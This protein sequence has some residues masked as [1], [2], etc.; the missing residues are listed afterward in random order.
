MSLAASYPV[1][2]VCAVLGLPRSSF[3]YHAAPP[4]ASSI[5]RTAMARL[6]AEWP[7]Y[8]YRRLTAQLRREGLV[9]NILGDAHNSK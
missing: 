3:Y 5:R 2:V 8:G 7:T 6:A 9:A 4:D 1:S